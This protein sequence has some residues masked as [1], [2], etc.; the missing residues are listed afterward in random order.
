MTE[1]A[2]KDLLL[3]LAE[4]LTNATVAIGTADDPT[5]ILKAAH[6]LEVGD[7]VLFETVPGSVSEITAGTIYY[8]K[9]V[10]SSGAFRI[11]LTPTGTAIT[12]TDTIADL[13]MVV[14]K[15]VGGLRTH[16]FSFGSEAIDGTWYG[17]NQWKKIIDGAGIRSMSLSGEGVYNDAA[18]FEAMQDAAV[19]NTHVDLAWVDVNVGIVFYGSFKL[20][21]FE[22]SGSYDGEGTFSISAESAGAITTARAA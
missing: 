7:L 3:K 22:S 17:S 6:G 20:T 14:Y 21:A 4:D 19:A 13:D 12:F 5:S 8:V 15:T 1:R 2:G 18:N 11:A 16:N 10:P 9:S